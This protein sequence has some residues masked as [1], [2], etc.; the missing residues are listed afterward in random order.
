MRTNSASY[1]EMLKKRPLNVQALWGN[2]EVGLV[3]GR[4]IVR[5]FREAN[6]IILAANARNPLTIKGVFRAAKKLNAAVFIEI[7]KSEATYCA[8]N[9]QNLPEYA[10]KTS[11]ELGHGVIFGLHVDH[12]AIKSEADL[13]KAVSHIPSIIQEGW[14]SVAIDASHLPD[15]ENLCSTRDVAMH[16]P[17]YLGLEVEVGE[18][19]GPG[20][21]TTVEEAKFFI[22]GLNSWGIFPDLLAI[23]NGSLH[24]TYDTGQQEGIDLERTLEIANAIRPYGA[25]IA[26]H[27]ISGTPIEK[28]AKFARFGINKGNVATLFQ[29]IIF[30]IKMDPD[31]GNAITENGAYVKEPNRGVTEQ[32]WQKIVE[33][34][35]AQGYSRKDGNYKKA[36]LPMGDIIQSESPEIIGRIVDE[37][38]EWATRFIKA[39]NAVDSAD[40]VLEFI[41]KRSDHN[42]TPEQAIL[43]KR[44]DF[45]VDRVP[46]HSLKDGQDYTD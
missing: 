28:V 37:T 33:W 10:V 1:K 35:D 7:A 13:F 40:R 18:I 16:I 43:G 23:S 36:N 2:E 24:G 25:S 21:L 30:G 39:F 31:T 34:C 3:S 32:T 5:A 41:A 9:F 17:P 14:T 38:E 6:A 8:G 46:G 22:G 20:E 15:W 26:Q 29:N 45:T 12:Y 19:K 4:D 27:G 42:G 44:S 11:S